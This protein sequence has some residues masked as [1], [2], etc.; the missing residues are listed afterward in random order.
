MTLL[1]KGAIKPKIAKQTP[2]SPTRLSALR[3]DLPSSKGRELTVMQDGFASVNNVGTWCH[4]IAFWEDEGKGQVELISLDSKEGALV[5]LALTGSNTGKRAVLW[6]P[7]GKDHPVL[8]PPMGIAQAYFNG[9]KQF[10]KGLAVQGGVAYFGVSYARAPPLRQTVPESLL[11][12]VDLATRREKWTRV[13]RSNGIINQIMTRTALGDI[14]LPA[15]LSSVEL[16]QHGGGGKLVNNCRD[17]EDPEDHPDLCRLDADI[18]ERE[19][20]S[21]TCNRPKAKQHCCLCRGG[22]REKIPHLAGQLDSEILRL[23][24]DVDL[25]ATFVPRRNCLG[26]SGKTRRIAL[27]HKTR[28]IDDVYGNLNAIVTHLCNLDVAPLHERVAQLGDEG[29]TQEHQRGHGNAVVE[30]GGVDRFKPGCTAIQ[31]VFSSKHA[32]RVYHFPWLEEWLPMLQEHIL[33]PLGIPLNRIL[34]MQLANMP[35][36][37]DISI[38]ADKNAWVAAAHR[39]HVPIITHS[40]VYFLVRLGSPGKGDGHFT[41]L[42]I[43]ADEGEAFEFNNS[44]LH[45]VKNLG[46]SRVHLIIDHVEKPIYDAEDAAAEYLVK[47]RPGEECT[48]KKGYPY[49]TCTVGEHEEL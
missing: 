21:L 31:L 6:S 7:E 19:A 44:M 12:A 8:E 28:Q 43:K 26:R 42:R 10:S 36:G 14:L 23:G 47:L 49:L 4:G 35:P 3:R 32:D 16:T 22:K 39:I 11:V 13:V 24:E 17:L 38:H 45:R 5:S 34:R 15:D 37:S 29:F 25:T 33:G 46:A 18:S 48:Q 40:D 2:D 30:I 1:G 20:V 41:H 9:A 27:K